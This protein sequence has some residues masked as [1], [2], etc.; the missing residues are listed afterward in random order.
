MQYEDWLKDF[1]K[2]KKLV[3]QF[4]QSVIDAVHDVCRYMDDG[5][6]LWETGVTY[7]GRL[8]LREGTLGT[9][10]VTINWNRWSTL[11][12]VVLSKPKSCA[13]SDDL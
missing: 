11:H 3:A 1:T 6:K 9:D 4:D 8:V 2:D 10:D 5:E 12:D 7:T 13:G